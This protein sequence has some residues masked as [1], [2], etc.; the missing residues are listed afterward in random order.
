MQTTVPST[1][2][3]ILFKEASSKL[4][5]NLNHTDLALL[6]SVGNGE[7]IDQLHNK[8]PYTKVEVTESDEKHLETLY[9]R[10]EKVIATDFLSLTTFSE[11]QAILFRPQENPPVKEILKAIDLAE[12]Q[13]IVSSSV[14]FIVSKSLLQTPLTEEEKQLVNYLNHSVNQIDLTFHTIDF[15]EEQKNKTY[16]YGLVNIQFQPQ[17]K[18]H[19]FLESAT[20]SSVASNPSDEQLSMMQLYEGPNYQN[21]L[22]NLLKQYA[23]FVSLLKQKHVGQMQV[24][25][26]DNY[27]AEKNKGEDRYARSIL[28]SYNQESY[29]KELAITRNH[30]W[31]LLLKTDVFRKK[32][33]GYGIFKLNEYT[34]RIKDMELTEENVNLAVLSLMNNATTILTDSLKDWFEKVTSNHL[35][36]FS[37]NIQFY[38]G[39]KTNDAY[40]INK[41]IVYPMSYSGFSTYDFGEGYPL[42]E[43]LSHLAYHVKNYVEDLVKMFRLL[44]PT[45]TD[46]FSIND[47]GDFE[48]ECFRIKM[49][50]KGTLHIWFKQLDLLEQINFLVGQQYNWVP[51]DEEI[52]E[53]EAA[54]QFVSNEFPDYNPFLLEI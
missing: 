28:H 50:K 39:W 6:P 17:K 52:Q 47:Y 5:T 12:A 41:K 42:S 38:N 21:Q 34:S 26:A 24:N 37:K 14:R 49:F 10:E 33:T 29:E 1:K 51:S 25:Y 35:A 30:F 2:E 16:T 54:A 53:T 43:N 3:M 48:N 20:R 40:K 18:L 8:C 9:Q 32:L 31:E 36:A 27:L 45:I 23:V 19:S 15:L 11:F 13:Q 44:D 46:Q 4:L 22:H 7:F